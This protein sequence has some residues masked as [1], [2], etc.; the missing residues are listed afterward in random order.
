MAAAIGAPIPPVPRKATI[1]NVAGAV[2][3]P[4]AGG[5]ID[6]VTRGSCD[7]TDIEPAA[8][9]GLEMLGRS[10]VDVREGDDD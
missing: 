3:V 5:A 2:P 4:F 6:G 8:L 1:P 7:P 9:G 10:A